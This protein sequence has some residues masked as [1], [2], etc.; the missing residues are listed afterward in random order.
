MHDTEYPKLPWWA[1]NEEDVRQ[2]ES[3]AHACM[4]LNVESEQR[5]RCMIFHVTSSNVAEGTFPLSTSGQMAFDLLSRTCSM[6]EQGAEL[7]CAGVSS[8][9]EAQLHDHMN[10]A[11]YLSAHANCPLTIE[12]CLKAHA[13]LMAHAKSD[14]DKPFRQGIRT[15]PVFA[16]CREFIDHDRIAGA[17]NAALARY[18]ASSPPSDLRS[19]IRA[20]A[21]LFTDIVHTI[22]PFWDGNGRLGRMLVAMSMQRCIGI[23]VPLV[24]GH[25]KVSKKYDA[26]ILRMLRRLDDPAGPMRSHILECIAHR[27]CC[28]AARSM[29]DVGFDRT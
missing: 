27:Y 16:S 4:H 6:S 7:T 11:R 10:A 28:L 19:A 8:D 29:T 22:H 26:I 2:L 23:F 3:N 5:E 12:V 13:I 25:D 15:G 14:D 18:N 20:S 9:A 17:L 24:N 1:Q 21:Q